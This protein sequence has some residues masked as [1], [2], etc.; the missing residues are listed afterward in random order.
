MLC[1]RSRVSKHS[2]MLTAHTRRQTGKKIFT[3]QR[4]TRTDTQS[5]P[6]DEQK[7]GKAVIVVSTTS[8]AQTFEPLVMGRGRER[9][10]ERI[11]RADRKLTAHYK[12]FS[13]IT[14]C[15]SEYNIRVAPAQCTPSD[16]W[17]D[18]IRHCI[19]VMLVRASVEQAPLLST[20]LSC[21]SSGL[22][23]PCFCP[24]LRVNLSAI[25]RANQ[26]AGRKTAPNK[27]YVFPKRMSERG[28]N[29]NSVPSARR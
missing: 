25:S 3:S 14:L 28:N 19:R 12:E 13:G 17:F 7:E 1:L 5:R 11:V 29:C 24:S 20:S 6:T 2:L 8:R 18:C 10:G 9:E 23:P 15:A 21:Q 4:D 16:L 26:Y 27:I 22:R